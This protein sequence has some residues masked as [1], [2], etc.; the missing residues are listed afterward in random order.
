MAGWSIDSEEEGVYCLVHTR[1]RSSRTVYT[2][3]TLG[4]A[5]KLLAA[6]ELTDLMSAGA[7]V[8]AFARAPKKT[9]RNRV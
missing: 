7:P 1:G 5:E 4:D 9:R 3:F 2:A 8:E 6:M